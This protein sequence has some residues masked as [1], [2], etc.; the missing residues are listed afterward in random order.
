MNK[1]SRNLLPIFIILLIGCQSKTTLRLETSPA[2]AI[3]ERIKSHTGSEA[4]LINFWATWCQPCVE[5]FP[6]IT[7]LTDKYLGQELITYFVSVDFTDNRDAVMAFLEE[8][9]VTG[10]SFIKQDGNDNNFI[11][12]ISADWTGAV[13]FTMLFSKSDGAIAH[14]WEGA[15]SR[16]QFEQA[17]LSAINS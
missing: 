13:P 17:I 2:E 5:E 15:A 1:L 9:G 4:V 11:N 7:D 3:L 14:L 12:S 6:I 10:L 8:Q 16:E